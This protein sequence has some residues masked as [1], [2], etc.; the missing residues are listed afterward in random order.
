MRTS[1]CAARRGHRHE[2]VLDHGA[3]RVLPQIKTALGAYAQA[4]L[5]AAPFDEVL[6]GALIPA[7]IHTASTALTLA[8]NIANAT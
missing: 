5:F 2:P 1:I 3:V 4:G 7:L 8:A 6:G